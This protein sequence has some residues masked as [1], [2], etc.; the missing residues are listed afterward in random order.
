MEEIKV[1]LII[2]IYK[3]APFMPKLMES[4]FNQTHRNIEIILVDDGSP[5][6]S[7]K[8]CD[9]Y[10]KQDNRVIVIHKPNGG[11]CDARNAGMKIM[12]GE[13]FSVID[14]DDWIELDYVDYLLD[15]ATTY[16]ADMALTDS[17][18]T[19]RDKKQ[20]DS[21][22][23]EIWTPDAM[24]EYILYPKMPIGP[25]NKLYRTDFV[26]KHH[27]LYD[28][29][30]SG[31]TPYFIT[32][33]ANLNAKIVKGHRRIYNYRLNNVNSAL[34]SR[35]VIYGQ[36]ALWN[37]K[38]VRKI[39]NT[40]SPR[41]LHV[42][43]WHIYTNYHGLL[44]VII[45]T[46]SYKKYWKDYIMCLLMIRIKFPRAIYHMRKDFTSKQCWSLFKHACLPLR[47]EKKQIQA[48]KICLQ[49]DL[50]NPEL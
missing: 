22:S 4:V 44:R 1:S 40:K 3:S 35:A 45:A 17:V 28:T 12:S 49:N 26:R 37:I 10:A 29:L 11:V 23:I 18:F 46:N 39:T 41:L 9:E 25:W 34:T 27:L 5:D 30:P 19:T 21:D 24:A 38:N 43:D 42:I 31:E 20:N 14:G 7:G 8:L 2:A 15:L 33:V 6:E 47:Y 36:N 13:Y 50:Q 32:K 16:N 48:E